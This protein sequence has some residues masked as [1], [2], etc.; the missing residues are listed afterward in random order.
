MQSESRIVPPHSPRSQGHRTPTSDSRSRVVLEGLESVGESWRNVEHPPV[1]GRQVTECGQH[2][3]VSSVGDRR[4]RRIWRLTTADDLDLLVRWRLVVK[5]AQVPALVLNDTLHCTSRVSSPC[6]SN[7]CWHQ[8]RAKN[9]R[10]SLT[11]WRSMTN[12]PRNG[13]STKSKTDPLHYEQENGH[14]NHASARG[15]SIEPTQIGLTSGL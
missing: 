8:A 6:A 2:R 13:V 14:Q 5:P 3:S 11:G 1:C 4:S 7:S 12:A 9:P 15:E 10:S